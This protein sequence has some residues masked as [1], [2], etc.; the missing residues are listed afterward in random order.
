MD[1]FIGEIR[2]LPYNFAPVGWQ[3][4]NGALLPISEN[5]ALYALI[6]T[7]YGGDGV[8]TFAV[9]DLRGRVPIHQGT[10]TGLSNYVLGQVAGSETVTLTS[11]QM[12]AHTHTVMVTSG[13]AATG[14]PSGTM[15]PGAISGDTMYT[16]DLTGITA[17]PLI[18]TMIG[19]AGG[20]QPHDN[21]MPTLTVRFCIALNGIWPSQP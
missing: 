20:N 14:M 2:L 12:P 4:C 3:D 5:D 10:G 9:P 6:G 19:P 8:N 17:F 16:S 11:A 13:Q 21:T 7:T 15:E 18:N 1:P